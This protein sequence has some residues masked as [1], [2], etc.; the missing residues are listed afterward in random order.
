MILLA[1]KELLIA[2]RQKKHT[3]T[4]FLMTNKGCVCV[5]GGGGTTL[6]MI[7]FWSIK[8]QTHLI[9]TDQNGRRYRPMSKN[10]K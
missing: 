6:K 7:D 5:G 8:A 4:Q 10:D 9:E 3:N 2:P 1:L